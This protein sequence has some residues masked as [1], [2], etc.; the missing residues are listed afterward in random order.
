MLLLAI[1]A[2]CAG[3]AAAGAERDHDVITAEEIR[4]AGTVDAYELVE[5]HRP[6]WLQS[7][8]GRSMRLSTDILVYVNNVRMGDVSSLRG[9]NLE[10]V[11]SLRYLDGASASAQLP[12]VGSRHVEGAIVIA[13]RRAGS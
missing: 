11:T 12:G 10:G 7:R 3:N 13:T 2:A 5:R 6:R 9:F 1:L 4:Q 8:G